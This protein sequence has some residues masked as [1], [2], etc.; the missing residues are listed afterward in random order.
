[1]H[2]I[3]QWRRELGL[4]VAEVAELCGISQSTL[5]R[6]EREAREG[7]KGFKVKRA[8]AHIIAAGLDRPLEDLFDKIEV[9][10][11]GRN[12]RTGTTFQKSRRGSHG[13]WTTPVCTT[14]NLQ[15]A[16]VEIGCP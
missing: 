4:D 2:K 15:H 11:H 14:C 3:E 6:I 16:L 9:S 13:Q 1:M 12:P 8:T 10:D 7:R 5:Y